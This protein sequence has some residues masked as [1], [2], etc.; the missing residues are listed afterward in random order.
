MDGVLHTHHSAEDE[1]IW[2]R[3]R[4]RGA[5]GIASIVD[6]MEEEHEDIHKGYLRATEA[7][8]AWRESASARSA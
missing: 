2:P 1:H 6:V 7:L 4:E 5:A 8:G 3:L